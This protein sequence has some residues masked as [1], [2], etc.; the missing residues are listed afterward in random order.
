MTENAP[1][2]LWLRRAALVVGGV[3]LAWLC[4]IDAVSQTFA[5]VSPDTVLRLDGDAPLAVVQ[6]VGIRMIAPKPISAEAARAKLRGSLAREPLNAKALSYYGAT[7][8]KQKMTPAS[9]KYFVLAERVSRR[10]LGAQMVFVFEAAEER[11][12]EETLA[13]I[14]RM[15]RTNYAARDRLFPI[16]ANVITRPDGRRAM[17]RYVRKDTPWLADFATF[18]IDQGTDP[19]AVTSWV[20]GMGG[21]PNGRKFR[22]VE[23]LLFRALDARRQYPAIADLLTVTKAAPKGLAQSMTIS[24][25]ALIPEWQPLSWELAE[26]SGLIVSPVVNDKGD[27]LAFSISLSGGISGNALR[28]IVLLPAGK[29]RLKIDQRSGTTVNGEPVPIRSNWEFSCLDGTMAKSLWGSEAAMARI[30]E[31]VTVP[32]GCRI[33]QIQLHVRAPN[34]HASSEAL[35]GPI[36]LQ[37][38]SS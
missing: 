19:S 3:C 16:L 13:R 15:L 2:K 37:R 26:G 12:E 25:A 33:Q 22:E 17:V 31:N 5:K 29:Y 23:M 10:D 7:Y 35:V 9:R 18:A 11:K 28:K 8:D 30:D 4:F 38:V 20:T 27:G 24:D 36:L 6:K 34:D 21:L 14:S 32:A 1:V